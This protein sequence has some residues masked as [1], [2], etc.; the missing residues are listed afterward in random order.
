MY[1]IMILLRFK[2]LYLLFILCCGFAFCRRSFSI[3]LSLKSSDH[4]EA[5][6]F[7]FFIFFF[8]NFRTKHISFKKQCYQL[9]VQFFRLI[10]HLNLN[11]FLSKSKF[12]AISFVNMYLIPIARRNVETFNSWLIILRASFHFTS[13]SKTTMNRRWYV[14]F[15]VVSLTQ[16]VLVVAYIRNLYDLT[17]YPT[18][19]ACQNKCGPGCRGD[20]EPDEAMTVYEIGRCTYSHSIFSNETIAYTFYVCRCEKIVKDRTFQPYIIQ[21]NFTFSW[22]KRKNTT[23]KFNNQVGG[24]LGPVNPNNFRYWGERQMK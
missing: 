7:L 18:M 3:T 13:F 4:P 1:N 9:K 12:Y 24:R 16:T 21:N 20:L 5:Y 17:H 14:S 11:P 19:H 23:Y 10:S 2:K 6:F 8:L 22:W 15:V